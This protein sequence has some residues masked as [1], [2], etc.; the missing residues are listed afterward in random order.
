VTGSGE[1]PLLSISHLSKTFPGQRALDSVEI[2]MRSGSVHSVVGH[3]G[4]GKSTLIKILSGYEQSDP[5]AGCEVE[6]Q[7]VPLERA[8]SLLGL[9]FMHQD[10]ALVDTLT[11][12]E[13]FFL[14]DTPEHPL[15]V[16]SRR[17]TARAATHLRSMGLDEDLAG[18]TVGDLGMVERRMVALARC[19][20]T[21]GPDSSAV[22]AIAL[23]EPTEGLVREQANEILALIGRVTR[24]G[25]AVLFVSHRIEDVVQ[26][27]DE[28]T[29]FRDGRV[30]GRWR[31]GQID[32]TRL[33]RAVAGDGAASTDAPP[34]RVADATRSGTNQVIAHRATAGSATSGAGRGNA[35]EVADL[36]TAALRGLSLVVEPGEI[37]GFTGPDGSGREDVLPALFGALPTSSG[38]VKV[39]S[40]VMDRRTPRKSVANGVVY[41]PRDRAHDGLIP[42]GSV[43][44]NVLLTRP[45]RRLALGWLSV[46][47]ERAETVRLAAFCSVTPN[48]PDRTCDTLSG[49]NQQKV[50]LA[51]ALRAEPRV[52]LID[53]PF[54]G[55]DEGARAVLS[56]C[57]AAFA[58]RDNAVL[59]AAAEE[60]DLAQ[61]CT[62]VFTLKDGAPVASA[63]RPGELLASGLQ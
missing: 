52:L 60:D 43:R 24:L 35:V 40:T 61:L 56:E 15:W 1:P 62:R 51:R 37:V 48:A 16:S 17:D 6:G 57:I 23:D 38:T 12:A 21:I 32:V 5:G 30:A 3:N 18:R 7:P 58:A 31:R 29:L 47:R 26:V 9:R 20:S 50:M 45:L 39:F 14:G 22:R 33:T 19:V 36:C 59:V 55:V 49:G 44:E 2:S 41:V 10:L 25:I 11:V 54:A 28:I 27:S 4:S 34:A 8:T 63:H 46:R 42:Q 13:N 53:E